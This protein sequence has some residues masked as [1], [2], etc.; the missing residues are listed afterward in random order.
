M[1]LYDQIKELF[2][3]YGIPNNDYI[4]IPFLILSPWI[5][6]TIMR[7]LIRN[8]FPAKSDPVKVHNLV[9]SRGWL[10]SIF[11]FPFLF[12]GYFAFIARPWLLMGRQGLY[13]Y[14]ER[15]NPGYYRVLKDEMQG[16]SNDFRKPGEKFRVAYDRKNVDLDPGFMEDPIKDE[17]TVVKELLKQVSLTQPAL[18]KKIKNAFY[19]RRPIPEY[20]ELF[21]VIKEEEIKEVMAEFIKRLQN[22][23]ISSG[24]KLDFLAKAYEL[25]FSG[26]TK[27]LREKISR[28]RDRIK[29]AGM[30]AE[31]W[32]SILNLLNKDELTPKS[33][34]FLT[35]LISGVKKR[36]SLFSD[37][38]ER[39]RQGLLQFYLSGVTFTDFFS[40]HISEDCTRSMYFFRFTTTKLDPAFMLFKVVED[41][42]WVGN[43]Y[44]MILKDSEGNEALL[45]DSFQTRMEH[46]LLKASDGQIKDTLKTFLERLKSY[47]T[48]EG[49]KMLLVSGRSVS[50]RSRISEILNE[51]VSKESVNVSGSFKKPGGIAHRRIRFS[52]SPEYIQALGEINSENVS[53]SGQKILLR[54]IRA[55]HLRKN[56]LKQEAIIKKNAEM[57]SR[58]TDVL[59]EYTKEKN[60]IGAQ[61]EEKKAFLQQLRLT[62]ERETEKNRSASA[63][64]ISAELEKID[65][66]VA[67]LEI[68][69]NEARSKVEQ[70]EGRI[71]EIQGNLGVENES[72]GVSP[73][74]RA[75]VYSF[76]ISG[77]LFANVEN[78]AANALKGDV[79]Y[80]LPMLAV[81][82]PIVAAG[83]LTYMLYRIIKNRKEAERDGYPDIPELIKEMYPKEA[84]KQLK[85]GRVILNPRNQKQIVLIKDIAEQLNAIHHPENNDINSLSLKIINQIRGADIDENI[86]KSLL[87]AAAIHLSWA[88]QKIKFVN[89]L[90]FIGR[91]SSIDQRSLVERLLDYLC[92]P[93]KS[94]QELS[95]R[96][97][98]VKQLTVLG[99]RENKITEQT[100]QMPGIPNNLIWDIP[101]SENYKGE[102]LRIGLHAHLDTTTHTPTFLIREGEHLVAEGTGVHAEAGLDDAV[103]LAGIMEVIQDLKE[104]GTPHPDIRVIFTAE[105]EAGKLG[106]SRG[107]RYLVDNYPEAFNDIDLLISIDGPLLN[108]KSPLA[109]KFINFG[110]ARE[111]QKDVCYEVIKKAAIKVSND[112]NSPEEFDFSAGDEQTFKAVEGLRIAHFRANYSQGHTLV[113]SI[114]LEHL[115]LLTEWIREIAQSLNRKPA[116]RPTSKNIAKEIFLNSLPVLSQA[117]IQ[118]GI[119]DVISNSGKLTPGMEF[120]IYEESPHRR[121]LQFKHVSFG[122]LTLTTYIAGKY[123]DSLDLAID[124]ESIFDAAGNI[125]IMRLLNSKSV[126]IIKKDGKDIPLSAVLKDYNIPRYFN[127]E[128]GGLVIKNSADNKS[129]EVIEFPCKG[130]VQIK[131]ISRGIS[132]M[133]SGQQSV[134]FVHL[135]A[136]ILT[137][138]WGRFKG[139]ELP[140]LYDLLKE[141]YD[142]KDIFLGFHTHP[143]DSSNNPGFSYLDLDE[144]KNQSK[145]EIFPLEL[146]IGN[147]SLNFLYHFRD[148]ETKQIREITLNL[149][150]ML[151]EEMAAE[152]RIKLASLVQQA[153]SLPPIVR[154]DKNFYTF[155]GKGIID[156][157]SL[158]R[159]DQIIQQAKK[160][161]RGHLIWGDSR[162]WKDA[163]EEYSPE[164]RS[165]IGYLRGYPKVEVPIVGTVDISEVLSSANMILVESSDNSPGIV[166]NNENSYQVAFNDIVDNSI[167]IDAVVY[168]NLSYNYIEKAAL[169]AHEAIELGA[170]RLCREKGIH[171]MAGLADEVDKMAEDYE[172]TITGKSS[173]GKGSRLDE[174]IEQILGFTAL[175]RQ[176]EIKPT[177]SKRVFVSEIRKSSDTR[178]SPQV[179]VSSYQKS[180]TR[181]AMKLDVMEYSDS[182]KALDSLKTLLENLSQDTS[183]NLP[184]RYEAF[185]LPIA[186]EI[187]K[188][189]LF[190]QVKGLP[191]DIDF[192]AA[193]SLF[194]ARIFPNHVD[195]LLKYVSNLY[196]YMSDNRRSTYG[197]TLRD[198]TLYIQRSCIEDL[199]GRPISVKEIYRAVENKD[200]EI[201]AALFRII[202]HE[203]GGAL[204]KL[205][206]EANQDLEK[207]FVSLLSKTE[208]RLSTKTEQELDKINQADNLDSIPRTDWA[209]AETFIHDPSLEDIPAEELDKLPSV[210]MDQAVLESIRKKEPRNE[211]MGQSAISVEQK[212][213]SSDKADIAANPG[214]ID[215]SKIEITLKDEKFISNLNPA[216]LKIL[217]AARALNE[218]QDSLAVLYVHEVRLILKDNILSERD[219]TQGALLQ[220]LLAQLEYRE[221]LNPEAIE[222]CHILQ[223]QEII[224]GKR[225]A[226]SGIK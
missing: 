141:Q 10:W 94:G 29:K 52:I 15:K 77:F 118:N 169:L 20:R 69:L 11:A 112:D 56:Q 26:Q 100:P 207:L 60:G 204:F 151:K 216:D 135:K 51:L 159:I 127:P 38:T 144:L 67:D 42:R 22:I 196:I 7:V 88:K 187:R 73:G 76:L 8:I 217:R 215:L 130:F 163:K 210:L 122:K 53:F 183:K 208:T 221:L 58:L 95:L 49:F 142:P 36:I 82:I 180:E 55:E 90:R 68:Q 79:F 86:R 126:Y 46:P 34:K 226:F 182:L 140:H 85:A 218:G 188:A 178:L 78:A 164:I 114:K 111:K 174:R 107:A 219:I 32:Q 89:S 70:Q 155:K 156:A 19:G 201:L 62:M 170:K 148:S 43:L 149:R 191:V 211:I 139:L 146:V 31:Y 47:L 185:P 154:Q 12:I 3:S 136:N 134:P 24:Q 101:A 1:L 16:L 66:T 103:A 17:L 104:K 117:D 74:V 184:A 115:V 133:I 45:L 166:V 152:D 25:I 190:L 157:E 181:K 37:S 75:A 205:S 5:I 23:N 138:R 6:S 105:E 214:G 220:S 2:I 129:A 54:D 102:P 63:N 128:V 109:A 153:D 99:G 28:S 172:V 61:L 48:Q 212:V 193:L 72:N 198:N 119:Q 9:S 179:R 200:T 41:G 202:I 81:F 120:I 98:I 80:S 192:L 44:T 171:W 213:S 59:S 162:E 39:P 65:S 209:A 21:E 71:K 137:D 203:V 84:S 33:S 4:V 224:S 225:L 168:S 91:N 14:W 87:I 27:K 125:F 186:R 57:L 116:A 93:S 35:E 222:F 121:L 145:P 223:G 167:K 147:R 150:Q 189:H 161:G 158:N 64:V 195:N 124:D 131:A 13:S 197:A 92:I 108:K 173:V 106:V 194:F 123:P 132:R 30:C 177:E 176:T 83:A 160:E 165:I 206:H 18:Y 110:T 97:Y 40:G 113:D 50:S 96:E 143:D 175:L 199:I